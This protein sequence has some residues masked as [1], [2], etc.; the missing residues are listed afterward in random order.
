MCRSI[1]VLCQNPHLEVVSKPRFSI[2]G[3]CPYYFRTKNKLKFG[4]L[5]ADY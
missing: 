1:E 5:I 2:A 3:G 4:P